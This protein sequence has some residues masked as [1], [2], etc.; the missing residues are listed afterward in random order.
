MWVK[1]GLNL[2]LSQQPMVMLFCIP[3]LKRPMGRALFLDDVLVAGTGHIRMNLGRTGHV[4]KN[5]G[6]GYVMCGRKP[7]SPLGGK[8][9]DFFQC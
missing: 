8:N 7:T 2:V 4:R 6:P 9:A 5:R 1:S 3:K